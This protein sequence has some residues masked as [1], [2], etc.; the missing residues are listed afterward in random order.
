[1]KLAPL[2]LALLLAVPASAGWRDVDSGDFELNPPPAKGTAAYKADFDE[3]LA[4]QASRSH[5]Q[6][7][8]A[9]AQKSPSLESFYGGSG[10]LTDAELAKAKP[11]FSQILSQVSKVS[12][13]FKLRFSRPRPW[14]ADSRVQPCAPKPSAMTSYPSTHAMAGAVYGCSLAAMYPDR[15]EKLEERGRLAGDLRVIAGVHH[16]SDVAA[17]RLLAAGICGKFLAD[18]GFR[19]ELAAAK[20]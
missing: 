15:A 12:N 6:C 14:I 9:T 1:M 20:P 19:K 16:P 2:F 4:H 5:D 3:L 18:A 10:L 13:P 7:S 11:L 8:L 17:S